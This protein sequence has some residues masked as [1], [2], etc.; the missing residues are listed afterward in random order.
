MYETLSQDD[1]LDK[2]IDMGICGLRDHTELSPDEEKIDDA[3][4][5][6]IEKFEAH[7]FIRQAGDLEEKYDSWMDWPLGDDRKRESP[8]HFHMIDLLLHLADSPLQS[9]ELIDP[10]RTID[11]Y[12]SS[13]NEE[14]IEPGD[15]FDQSQWQDQDT[16]STWSE[17]TDSEDESYAQCPADSRPSV[18]TNTNGPILNSPVWI[19]NNQKA[20]KN[21]SLFDPAKDRTF[22]KGYSDY[23]GENPAPWVAKDDNRGV[24]VILW[25]PVNSTHN[26]VIRTKAVETGGVTDKDWV[27]YHERHIIINL[28]E[29]FLGK[30]S[31]KTPGILYDWDNLNNEFHPKVKTN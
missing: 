9:A 13:D 22:I 26:A 17:L 20:A 29:Y 5:G 10:V 6:M 1:D 7:N 18:C 21:Q 28:C 12:V 30:Y 11:E 14:L 31:V 8:A 25:C 15:E 16:L 23:T 19:D 4:K 24:S 3:F 2:M 27:I